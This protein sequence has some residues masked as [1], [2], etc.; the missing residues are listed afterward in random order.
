LYCARGRKIGVGLGWVGEGGVEKGMGGGVDLMDTT[1]IWMAGL[2]WMAEIW[3]KG[4]AG[5]REI[6]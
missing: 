1:M 6:T 5:L 3:I 4:G 2:A